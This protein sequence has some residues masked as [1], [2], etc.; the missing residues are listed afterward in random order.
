[1]AKRRRTPHFSYPLD[2]APA[3]AN[4]EGVRI[5]WY[6]IAWGMCVLICV[7]SLTYFSVILLVEWS[8]A[9][10]YGYPIRGRLI[11]YI[12]PL[13]F[14]AGGAFGLLLGTFP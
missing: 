14:I 6:L 9:R 13:T 2:A 10:R 5:V 12:L 7:G 4:H 11:A 8:Y 1:M 3:P